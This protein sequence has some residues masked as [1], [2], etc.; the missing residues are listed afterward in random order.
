MKIGHAQI[1]QVLI[2]MAKPLIVTIG[3]LTKTV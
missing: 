3:G 1:S 2:L